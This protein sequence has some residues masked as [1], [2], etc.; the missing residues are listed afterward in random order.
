V[1]E[2]N[3]K[4]AAGA[5]VA[6]GITLL[7]LWL[8]KGK[9]APPP[10]PG[11]ANLYGKITDAQTGQPVEGIEVSF[12]GYYGVTETNG[13]Y[14]IEDILPGGYEVAFYDPLGRYESALI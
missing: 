3:K 11:M 4:L 2:K 8:K 5:G 1:D 6:G 14:L 12:A 10:P 7:L 9:G 13:Y